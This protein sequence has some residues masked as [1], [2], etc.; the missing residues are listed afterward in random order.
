MICVMIAK[1]TTLP[2]TAA[3]QSGKSRAWESSS[4]AL[5]TWLGQ[6]EFEDYS[7]LYALPLNYP[8]TYLY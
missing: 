7:I 2:T 4:Q 1:A 5:P 8:R 6:I 3:R